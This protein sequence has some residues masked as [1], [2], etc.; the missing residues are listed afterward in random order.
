MRA[1]PRAPNLWVVVPARRN[2]PIEVILLSCEPPVRHSVAEALRADPAFHLLLVSAQ[3]VGGSEAVAA[4][5]PRVAVVGPGV[6]GE[7]IL[8]LLARLRPLPSS[9]RVI[10]LVDLEESDETLFRLVAAGVAGLLYGEVPT[11]RIV[12]AVAEA[13]AG[14]E[15]IAPAIQAALVRS[16]RTHG[17]VDR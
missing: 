16:L 11:S 5:G 14:R 3:P 6:S 7:D 12:S 9:T 13:A 10:A 4:L 2:R 15:V 17:L 8:H 1:A